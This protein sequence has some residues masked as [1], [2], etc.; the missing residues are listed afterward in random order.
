MELALGIL[1]VMRELGPTLEFRLTGLAAARD[2][3][4][5]NRP[6]RLGSFCML[7][8]DWNDERLLTRVSRPLAVSIP[9]TEVA[10]EAAVGDAGGG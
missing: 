1:S 5:R 2:D 7:A 3:M 9:E 6:L 10:V 8:A 4:E